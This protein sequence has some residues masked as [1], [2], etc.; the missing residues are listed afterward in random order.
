MVLRTQ[1]NAG[2]VAHNLHPA[3]QAASQLKPM[4]KGALLGALVLSPF[5]LMF[6][7]GG[8][9]SDGGGAQT[10]TGLDKN[11]DKLVDGVGA[12]VD[13]DGN[14]QADTIDINK[15]GI[16]DGPGVDTNGDGKVDG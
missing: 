12:W 2:R 5:L 13:A 15:D 4:A 14:K 16:P 8:S 11:N 1:R 7:C 6:A 3:L 9:S 10:G